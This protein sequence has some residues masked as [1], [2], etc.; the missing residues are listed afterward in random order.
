[1]IVLFHELTDWSG[2]YTGPVFSHLWVKGPEEIHEMNRG[3]RIS[4]EFSTLCH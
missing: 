4:Y 2:M 3:R 1:M